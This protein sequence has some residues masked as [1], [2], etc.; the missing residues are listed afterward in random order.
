LAT[1]RC[2]GTSATRSGKAG[3][4]DKMKI[5]CYVNQAEAFRKGIDA[6]HSSVQIEVDPSKLTQAQRD[7]IANDLNGGRVFGN[8]DSM[9]IDEPTYEGFLAAVNKWMG[10]RAEKEENPKVEATVKSEEPVPLMSES[11]QRREDKEQREQRYAARLKTDR[12]LTA[13]T[14]FDD[15]A[16]QISKFS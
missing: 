2:G 16:K 10:K 11:E 4:T 7:F 1:S 6:P 8:K 12:A 5:L 15:A 13:G 9:R 14:F 3:S